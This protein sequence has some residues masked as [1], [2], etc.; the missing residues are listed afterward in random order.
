LPKHEPIY[1]HSFTYYT[2]LMLLNFHSLHKWE[3]FGIESLWEKPGRGVKAKWK[4]EDI[5]FLSECLKKEPR[6]YNSFQLAD[7]LE[8]E[9][10]IK[11]SPDR[12]RRVLKKKESFG[13]ELVQVI[14][15]NKTPN[16]EK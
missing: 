16:N 2:S 15:E 1:I 11:L 8:K 4:E 13:K 5:E 10:S 7:K 12:L 9:R 6:T 14:K 3:E